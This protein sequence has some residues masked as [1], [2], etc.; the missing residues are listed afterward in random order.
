VTSLEEL[1]VADAQKVGALK[2][3]AANGGH[4]FSHGRH[5]FAF[6]NGDVAE[7]RLDPEIVEAALRTPS[8][9]AS[10]RGP[11]WVCLTVREADQHAVDRARAWFLSAYRAVDSSR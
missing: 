5:K 2:E 4:E 10:T 11:D 9:T 7:F 3:A 1:L 6:V 8:T